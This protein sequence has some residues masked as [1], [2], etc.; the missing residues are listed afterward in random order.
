M[1]HEEWLNESIMMVK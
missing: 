1:K